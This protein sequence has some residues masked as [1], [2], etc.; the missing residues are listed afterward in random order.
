MSFSSLSSAAEKI[1]T[2]LD[3]A[4][5]RKSVLGQ[6]PWLRKVLLRPYRKLINLHGRGVLMNIAGCLRRRGSAVRVLHLAE[7]LEKT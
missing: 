2:K 4:V 1:L 5:R 3:V 7:L 6:H